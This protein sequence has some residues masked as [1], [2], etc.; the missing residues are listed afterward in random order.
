MDFKIPNLTTSNFKPLTK[1]HG[2][3]L[4]QLSKWNQHLDHERLKNLYQQED[5]VLFYP[6]RFNNKNSPNSTP[7]ISINKFTSFSNKL[8]RWPQNFNNKKPKT[9]PF[10]HLA[11]SSAPRP[12]RRTNHLPTQTRQTPRPSQQKGTRSVRRVQK[13]SP[14]K[15]KKT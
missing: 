4:H 6:L 12:K 5:L 9:Y 15:L 13:Y 8:L 10:L 11:T 1:D 2:F 7:S 3:S 14:R